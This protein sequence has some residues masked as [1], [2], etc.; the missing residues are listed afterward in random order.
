MT[1]ISEGSWDTG[2]TMLKI[3]TITGITYIFVGKILNRS[4]VNK[5]VKFDFSYG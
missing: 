4:F 5:L 2:L 3:L 1:I